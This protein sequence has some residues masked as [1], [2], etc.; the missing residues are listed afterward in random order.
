VPPAMGRTAT[1]ARLPRNRGA[2]PCVPTVMASRA[3]EERSRGPAGRAALLAV[4]LLALLAAP[5]PAQ[6]LDRGISDSDDTTF[7]EPYWPGLHVGLARAVLPWDVALPQAANDPR[8]LEFDRYVASARAHGVTPMVAFEAS[9]R[10]KA[11]D[12]G[13]LAPTLAQFDAAFQAFRSAYPDVTR[14]APW[15]EPNRSDTTINPLRSDP[16]LA[17]RYW[18]TA[19]ADCAQCTVLAGDFA[20]QLDDDAYVDGYQAALGAARPA[21]WA[22]HAHGDVNDFQSGLASDARTSRYYL[23]KLDGTWA[24]S[25]VWIDEVGA[26]WRDASRKIWGDDSQ[27][28]STS[29]LLGLATLSPRVKAIY[30]YNYANECSSAARCGLQDRGLVSPSPLDGTSPGYDERGR[31]RPAYD[32]FAAGGP[33]I[34][35]SAPVAARVSLDLPAQGAATNDSTPSFS[36]RAVTGGG[37]A[38]TVTVKVFAGD[39]DASQPIQILTAVVAPDGSFSVDAAAPLPEGG[40]TA[41]AEQTGDG[42]A[43]GVS[44]PHSFSVDTTP[45]TSALSGGPPAVTGARSARFVLAASEPNARFECR[46][47]AGAF[48]PCASPASYARLALGPHSF[49]VRAVDAAGNVERFPTADTWRVASL[50]ASVLDTAAGEGGA[51]AVA[52]GSTCADACVLRAALYLDAGTARRLG[53]RGRAAAPGTPGLPRHGRYVRLSSTEAGRAGAGSVRVRLGLG[54]GAQRLARGGSAP[55]RVVSSVATVGAPTLVAARRVNL[56][57]PPP[58]LAALGARGLPLALDCSDACSATFTLLLDRTSARRLGVRGRI[59]R[60]GGRSGL[61][62][63]SYVALGSVTARRG[64]GGPLSPR[65]R[66][67][68]SAAGRLARAHAVPMRI[69]SA[70]SGTGT[71]A[72]ALARLFTPRP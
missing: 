26:R 59:V 19:Q 52:L 49:A 63:G 6:A 55:A 62:R 1:G 30:Y 2:S 8:K 46:L 3:H 65:L 12:G 5:A 32:V 4:L 10:L 47:D 15:N 28:R 35:P 31:R 22:F 40:Y 25:D 48:V 69:V 29:F 21:V 64:A 72:V 54:S 43:A 23:H 67:A 11:S 51:G 56:G 70:V 57:A 53:V 33:V 37:A 44:D 14:I 13:P 60:G 20:G 16:G 61:P 39:G 66:L 27:K 36:G 18:L 24:S 68:R 34:A 58:T 17:A 9:P 42:G 71:P 7:A 45:P 41:R 50:R 38:A